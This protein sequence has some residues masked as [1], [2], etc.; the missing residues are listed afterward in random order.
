MAGGAGQRHDRHLV[1]NGRKW[2]KMGI[3]AGGAASIGPAATGAVSEVVPK[4]LARL[5]FFGHLRKIF[6]MPRQSRPPG[7][8]VAARA[9]SATAAAG[10]RPR[11]KFF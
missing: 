8:K 10:P 9:F 2:A 7:P 11:E 4:V 1:E 5:E 6:E 3:R